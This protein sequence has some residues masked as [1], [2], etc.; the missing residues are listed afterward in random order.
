MSDAFTGF[1]LKDLSLHLK[2]HKI[3]NFSPKLNSS[4]NASKMLT[5]QFVAKQRDTIH[6]SDPTTVWLG[7]KYDTD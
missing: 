3:F 6:P 4:C 2:D 5:F 1:N 7:N